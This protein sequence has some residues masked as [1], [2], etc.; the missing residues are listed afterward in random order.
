MYHTILSLQLSTTESPLSVS[1]PRVQ[2]Y[3]P[4]TLEQLLALRHKFP[5]HNDPNKPQYRI[6][7]GNSEIGMKL[8]HR[9]SSVLCKSIHKVFPLLYIHAQKI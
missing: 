1:G 7:A 2:W 3:R 5:H 9:L 6:V 4:V 8:V